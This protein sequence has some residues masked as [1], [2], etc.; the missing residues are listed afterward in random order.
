MAAVTSIIAGIG[1][2]AG[3]AGTAVQYSGQRKAEK[4]Q[5]K[6]AELQANRDRRSQIRQAMLARSRALSAG[7]ATGSF[8]GSSLQGGLG[9]L[10]SQTATNLAGIN[11]GQEIG[12]QISSGNSMANL[13]GAISSLGGAVVQNS[14]TI[15]RVG[16]YV[17]GKIN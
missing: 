16:Q 9:S 10:S 13:G 2:A 12:A 4:A 8:F 3:L 5:K 6:A 1:V 11:Q 15:G 17:G 7:A 14:Q